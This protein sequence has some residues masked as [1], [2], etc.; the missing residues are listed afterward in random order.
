MKTIVKSKENCYGCS[1]CK[2]VC[3]QNAI[4]LIPDAEG[5]QY[6]KIDEQK[7]VNCSLCVHVCPNLTQGE[8]KMFE[9]K[10][11]AAQHKNSSVLYE[12]SSGGV[13][14]ALSD[15]ILKRNGV[16]FG[17][18]F[19][20]QFIVLHQSAETHEK[21]NKMRG[22]KYIQSNMGSIMRD[23]LKTLEESRHVMF[24]GTPCQVSGLRNYV[25]MRR[26]SLDGLYLCDFIC[27][28][29][30]SPMLWYEYVNYIEK[31][32][33][34]KLKKYNFR[35]KMK[36][37]HKSYPDIAVG[38]EECSNDYKNKNSF[39]LLYRTGLISRPS[40]YTCKFMSYKRYSDLT[41]ADF[42]NIG[43][44]APDMDDDKGTSQVLV[45]TAK[46]MEWFGECLADIRY[47]ECQ[48]KDV[49]QPHLE[50]ADKKP[51]KREKFWSYYAEQGITDTMARYGKG[52]FMSSCKRILVPITKKI[53]LYKV[54]GKLYKYLVV[55]RGKEKHDSRNEKDRTNR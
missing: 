43:K 30:A 2:N 36:G 19:D 35:G 26:K 8:N 5:F 46:G 29:V 41:I 40:C 3:P 33:G 20:N 54:A 17:A 9:Q 11:F 51:E 4:T 27:H 34:G 13:F 22:S 25:L 37:W 47:C 7:C 14:T 12:S 32:Q 10:Y 21:R 23:V 55:R 49:W 44:V 45:N 1:A 16:V 38:E 18:V 50:Y 24:V 15:Y 39:F 31:A 28:G 6:P 53:G 52:D 42:W 48:K